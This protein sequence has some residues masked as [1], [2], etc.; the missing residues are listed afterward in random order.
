[1]G[2]LSWLVHY[3]EGWERQRSARGGEKRRSAQILA[4][5][6][7]FVVPFKVMA[8]TLAGALLGV[9]VWTRFGEVLYGSPLWLTTTLAIYAIYYYGTSI[10]YKRP[11]LF[12]AGNLA[13]GLA[14]LLG[15]DQ[16]FGTLSVLALAALSLLWAG[17]SWA[18]ERAGLKREYRRV[19]GD[20]IFI[21]ASMA[22]VISLWRHLHSL[23]IVD[24]YHWG[25]VLTLDAAALF[26]AAL[27]LVV[28]AHHYRSRLPLY[29]ALIA[30]AVI[31]PGLSALA[32]LLAWMGGEIIGRGVGLEP[33]DDEDEGVAVLGRFAL[34][35]QDH[36]WVLFSRALFEGALFFSLLGLLISGLQM[37]RPVFAW[38]PLLF[39]PV[40][41]L[42][43]GLLTR[44]YR[45]PLLY[46]LSLFFGYVSIQEAVQKLLL[47]NRTVP[48]AMAAHLVVVAVVSVMGWAIATGYS[49][50]CDLRLRRVAKEQEP[51]IRGRRLFYGGLLH[52]MTSGTALVALGLL[53]LMSLEANPERVVPLLIS[54]AGV[55]ALFFALSGAVYQVPLWSYLSLTALSLGVLNLVA[56]VSL[57]WPKGPVGGFS[58]ALLGLAMAS[59]SW[60]WSGRPEGSGDQAPTWRVPSPWERSW[61][62]RGAAAR[63]LWMRPLVNFSIWLGTLAILY[64]GLFY[65]AQNWDGSGRFPTLLS[66]GLASLTFLLCTRV[67]RVGALYVLALGSG[68]FTIHATAQTLIFPPGLGPEAL[69]RHVLLA[70]CL[71]VMG[72]AIATGYSAWCGLRL[73]RVAQEEEEAIVGRRLFYGGLL[74]HMSCGVAFLALLQ[75]FFMSLEANPVQVPSILLAA[76]GVLA[77]FFGLS[78]AVYQTPLWSY[79]SLTALTLGVLNLVTV[80]GLPWPSDLAV[81][82]CL[83]ALGFLLALVASA[84]WKRSRPAIK[85]A[86]VGVFPSPW[87][88][89]PLTSLEER[90]RQLW[91]GPLAKASLLLTFLGMLLVLPSWDMRLATPILATFWFSAG[92]FAL[93]AWM[94]R[95][96]AL[97][98]MAA[99]AL[100][101]STYPLLAVV[102]QSY[103]ESAT[104]LTALALVLWAGSFLAERGSRALAPVQDGE[105]EEPFNGQS[106][107]AVPL[108]RC[109]AIFSLFSVIQGWFL[110]GVSDWQFLLVAY[111]GAAVVLFLSARNMQMA[112]RS[113]EARFFVYLAGLSMG[114]AQIMTLSIHWGDPVLGVST[115]G[116]ALVLAGVGL[117][118][119]GKLS[120]VEAGQTVSSF[121]SVYGEPLLHLALVFPLL[122]ISFVVTQFDFTQGVQTGTVASLLLGLGTAAGF[123]FLVAALTYLVAVRASGEKM[124]LHPAV[125]LG[126]L[127]LLVFAESLFQFDS[128]PFL[129]VSILVMNVLLGLAHLVLRNR[130]R[131]AAL[132]GVPEANCETAFYLW[133]LVATVGVVLGQAAYFGLIIIG[134]L[135]GIDP[136]GSGLGTSF[137]ACLFFFHFFYLERGQK[138][139]HLLIAASLT[140]SLWFAAFG[141]LTVDVAIA[142][143]G[144]LWVVVAAVLMR[145]PGYRALES[146]G[147]QLDSEERHRLIK[148]LQTWVG[149][150]LLLSVAVTAPTWVLLEPLLPSTGLT[151][152]LVTF[153]CLA[154]GYLWP[155]TSFEAAAVAAICLPGSVW[156]TLLWRTPS[157]EVMPQLGLVTVLFAA[158]YLFLSRM[159]LKT[160][161]VESEEGEEIEDTFWLDIG[162]VLLG[163]AVVFTMVSGG[164]AFLSAETVR[165]EFSVALTMVLTGLCWL[166]LAWDHKLEFL[167]Y[168]SEVAM[169]WTCLYVYQQIFGIPFG[170]NLIRALAVVA[171]SLVF[172]GLNILLA[173]GRAGAL[174]VFVR[175][176]YYTALFLPIALLWVIPRQQEAASLVIFAV[177]S[178]YMMVAH[179]AQKVWA[180]YVPALLYNVAL[181]IWIPAASENTGL[182]QLYVIPAALTVLIFAH[183][184]KGD[185][186]RQALAGIRTATSATILAVSTLEVLYTPNLLH[187]SVE[188]SVTLLGIMIGVALRIRAFVY[189]GFAFLVIGVTSQLGLQ[190]QGQAGIAR[191]VILITVGMM[192]LSTMVFFNL[193]REELLQR[194][195]AFIMSPE[196]E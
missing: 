101:V 55:L 130:D 38:A 103:I 20:S 110:W 64:Q 159:L 33:L 121:R 164:V 177:A 17:L 90:G 172:F 156:A 95:E 61:S 60:N 139:V 42:V 47:S 191:A 40:A 89:S 149:A 102:G 1:M 51:A 32:A 176:T 142:L 66:L 155:K 73:R 114:A 12:Y 169:A 82:V 134:T 160:T 87:P 187:F 181:Y 35:F 104:V 162:R 14:A 136:Q 189:T 86:G 24:V 100:W 36:R 68:F 48:E 190:I 183:L 112:E 150:L 74:H 25:P 152:F 99:V 30:V 8:W 58:L 125:I 132:L 18:G 178:F 41:A 92:V 3:F 39:M 96:P 117:V 107:Y 81:G 50:W 49:T 78:G 85:D 72:W 118:L 4:D 175:P 161:L 196:W 186:T 94:Y 192:V 71:S 46:L 21:A 184:H 108:A 180:L 116:F 70:G 135:E 19:L 69:S 167:V 56:A 44:I 105:G 195:R 77:L 93:A 109:A 28:C 165:P 31:A 43:L 151:L 185:L 2:V 158:S 170:P 79:A 119:L 148:L 29:G 34:P 140:G 113:A 63:E 126:G 182:L 62:A 52:H 57:P 84:L 7:R 54:A 9:T 147:F 11:V 15:L 163:L 193:K 23:N 27:S 26:L 6:P 145:G 75:L 144:L 83:A 120:G 133:P 131:V 88:V 16:P 166:Y 122:A 137:L 22:Y 91:A 67:H 53:F 194:Y 188:L 5:R 76:A 157:L 174:A 45:L 111:L 13:A 97:T 127:S 124:W 37:F 128:G 146:V 141:W 65:T 59:I 138:G 179:R 168:L 98:Y 129:L 10:L 143:L 154:A 106:V 80:V 171:L 115:A 153:G 173:R 123:T